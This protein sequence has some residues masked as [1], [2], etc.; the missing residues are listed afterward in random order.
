MLHCTV[1][2]ARLTCR[3]KWWLWDRGGQISESEDSLIYRASYKTARASQRNPVLKN[4]H[5]NPFSWGHTQHQ[6]VRMNSQIYK[7]TSIGL[8]WSL[9]SANHM[10]CSSPSVWFH[11][12]HIQITQSYHQNHK[13]PPN[14]PSDWRERVLFYCFTTRWRVWQRKGKAST[15]Q[16]LKMRELQEPAT[17]SPRYIHFED[18]S[19]KT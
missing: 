7:R 5:T 12:W 9:N 13:L 14:L 11:A 15:K 3:C 8:V 18:L 6:E 19:H 17:P 10:M 2:T 16:A 4:T 1:K